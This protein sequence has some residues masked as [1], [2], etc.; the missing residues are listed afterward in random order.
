MLFREPIAVYCENHQ[1][2]ERERD[3][4]KKWGSSERYYTWGGG[5][6]IR[7]KESIFSGL[8]V[9]RQCPLVLLV[10]AVHIIG[11]RFLNFFLVFIYSFNITPEGLHY[12]KIW[13]NIGRA[14]LGR[15][16][17]VTSGRAASCT[18][19]TIQNTQIYNF[20]S[21]LTGNILI[22]IQ[23]VPHRKHITSPLK[24]QPVNAV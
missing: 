1:F 12:S 23:F 7:K 5:G 3:R 14:T 8:K 4:R 13:T 18:M 2:F 24:V 10:E 16:F 9:P 15:N 21:Y 19:R 20:S 17:D 6:G 11:I 22:Q